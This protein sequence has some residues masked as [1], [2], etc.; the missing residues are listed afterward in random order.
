MQK[1]ATCFFILVSVAIEV[2]H[3]KPGHEMGRDNSP[4]LLPKNKML[5]HRVRSINDGQEESRGDTRCDQ[6]TNYLGSEKSRGEVNLQGRPFD[7]YSNR[8]RKIK[9][10]VACFTF[11]DGMGGRKPRIRDSFHMNHILQ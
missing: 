6:T 4:N 3:D 7:P 9:I 2:P 11:K 10:I 5:F 8:C 1:R